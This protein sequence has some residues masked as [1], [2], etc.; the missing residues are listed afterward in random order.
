MPP[1]APHWWAVVVVVLGILP[2]TLPGSLSCPSRHHRVRP[3]ILVSF[4][5]HP[6]F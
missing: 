6:S 1:P 5:S 4:S 2:L 3:T